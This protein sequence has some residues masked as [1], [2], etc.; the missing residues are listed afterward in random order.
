MIYT[1]TYEM[2][3]ETLGIFCHFR[4]NA[5]QAYGSLTN[6]WI[7]D[8]ATAIKV[9]RCL[10]AKSKDALVFDNQQAADD[11]VASLIRQS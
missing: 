1:I 11:F 10:D 6:N 9:K 7:V 2:K 8:G 3:S 5:E 4:K